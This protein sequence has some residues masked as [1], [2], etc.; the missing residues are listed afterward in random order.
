MERL[1]NGILLPDTWPPRYPTE[2]LREKMP[3]PYPETPPSVT[4]DAG[5]PDEEG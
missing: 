1:Y 2:T 3:V 4:G 5:A